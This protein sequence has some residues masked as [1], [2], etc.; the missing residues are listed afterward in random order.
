M[1]GRH[2]VG[3]AA[4]GGKKDRY[5]IAHLG[6]RSY[7]KGWA[8]FQS[9]A[10]R[11]MNDARYEFIQLGLDGPGRCPDY[12]RN[13]EVLAGGFSRHAMIHA[14]EQEEVDAVLSWSLCHETFSFATHEAIAAGCF[15]I[16]REGSGNVPHVL[17][18]YAPDSSILFSDV[19]QLGAFFEE[20]SALTGHL[21]DVRHRAVLVSGAGT[22]SFPD[23]QKAIDG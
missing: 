3:I 4:R 21:S 22:F 8:V 19:A 13:V 18:L 14:L 7:S 2:R 11:F 16:G 12:I 15:V 20:G 6:A 17:Q 10:E 23:F 9:L 5:R 1:R